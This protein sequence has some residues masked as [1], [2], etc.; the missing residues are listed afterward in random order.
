MEKSF[1]EGETPSNPE[2]CRILA[3]RPAQ[4]RPRFQQR[5]C[6]RPGRGAGNLGSFRRPIRLPGKFM[7]PVTG[8]RDGSTV[9]PPA[10]FRD[11]SGIG[12]RQSYENPNATMAVPSLRGED[13][14]E[15]GVALIYV[16]NVCETTV[17][18]PALSSEER[19]R[20]C[21]PLRLR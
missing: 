15:G 14:E 16:S 18:T 6:L 1:L 19:G 10:N 3:G 20:N 7:L 21:S 17:L 2:G 8:G 11:P 4:R 9:L 13:Q 12:R 5:N